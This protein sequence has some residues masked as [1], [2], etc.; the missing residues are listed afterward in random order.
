MKEEQEQ[1]AKEEE[2]EPAT[3]QEQTVQAEQY[4]AELKKA[5]QERRMAT[6]VETQ[7]VPKLSDFD[8]RKRE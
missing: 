3:V 2:E 7:V 6:V 4:L 1:A 8:A 5:G